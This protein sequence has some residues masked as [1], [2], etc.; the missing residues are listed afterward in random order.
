MINNALQLDRWRAVL[1][2]DGRVQIPDFLQPAAAEALAECL[3][4]EVPWQL[5]ERSEGESRTSPRGGYPD[6]AE[7][8]AR[9]QRCYARAGDEY[10]F[11][12]DTYMLV[13]AAQEGWDPE[14]LVH[15]ALVFFNT[16]EF[17][18]FARWLTGDAAITH[19]NAQCTRYRPGQFLMP[20]N[21]EDVREGRR[22]AYVLNLTRDWKPDWGGQLQFLD[23]DGAV[24]QTLMPRWNSLSLFRVPQRHQVTLVAPWA[25][26]PRHAITGWWL[27]RGAA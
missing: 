17:V 5:A 16:P 19:A 15:R 10:Q 4:R 3:E 7:L 14:L 25:A 12:Y 11:A 22:Y 26:G 1:A 2:R 9:L 18:A 27:A 21:D 8:A 20:H 24:V 23:A 6:P 13:R